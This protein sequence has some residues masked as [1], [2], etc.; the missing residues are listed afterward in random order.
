MMGISLK[1]V[2]FFIILALQCYKAHPQPYHTNTM[3]ANIFPPNPLNTFI[4]FLSL[5]PL[6]P[7]SSSVGEKEKGNLIEKKLSR[8]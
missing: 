4:P 8:P 5:S 2:V 6:Y 7:G 1:C 3:P